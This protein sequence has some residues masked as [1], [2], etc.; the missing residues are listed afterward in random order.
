MIAV[1]ACEIVQ[2][3]F[4]AELIHSTSRCNLLYIFILYLTER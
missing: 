1:F 3:M 2:I 4:S